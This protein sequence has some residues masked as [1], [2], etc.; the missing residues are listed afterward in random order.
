MAK[1]TKQERRLHGE[2]CALLEKD[3]LT[4]D[5]KLV[6]LERWQ[7]SANHINSAVGAFFTPQSL[8]RGVAL[9][10]CGR[11]IIDLCAGIGSLAFAY[12]LR[13]LSHLSGREQI[14]IT[15]VESNPDYIVVGK[16]LLPQ[17]TWIQAD[18]LNLPADIGH[19]DCAISNPPFGNVWS[20][21]PAPRVARGPF[22]YKV[23]DI[24]SGIADYGVFLI[25]QGSAPFRLS[26]VRCFEYDHESEAYKRFMKQ[27]GITLEPNCGIDTSGS[28]KE[29]HGGLTV[30]TEIV[31]ADFEALRR[32]RREDVEIINADVIEPAQAELFP[33]AA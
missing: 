3:V 1:L 26:G 12:H 11:K 10:T 9:E 29:W 17:A 28:V 2:A 19:F 7:E 25:P 31:L 4:Y 33:I 23:I 20:A 14:E 15:C 21:C 24:A 8:A 13:T 27:T 30:S 6:V 22:E 16:K 18:V 5:D 32:A